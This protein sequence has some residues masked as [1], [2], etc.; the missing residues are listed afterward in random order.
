MKAAYLAQGR[1][2]VVVHAHGEAGLVLALDPVSG[3]ES[4]RQPL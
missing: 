3:K 4:W 1:L 2:V